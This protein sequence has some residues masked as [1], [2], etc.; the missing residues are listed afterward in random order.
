MNTQSPDCLKKKTFEGK[1][2]ELSNIGKIQSPDSIITFPNLETT[3]YYH[4]DSAEN[5]STAKRLECQNI[6]TIK[7]NYLHV[8]AKY[9]PKVFELNKDI[10]LQY[11]T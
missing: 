9:N 1:G 8:P 10:I 5:A 2:Y 6:P 11:E 7:V 3:A 4:G